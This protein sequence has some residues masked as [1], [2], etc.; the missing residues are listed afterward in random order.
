MFPLRKSVSIATTSP[1]TGAASTSSVEAPEHPTTS[2]VAEPS[3]FPPGDVSVSEEKMPEDL[4]MTSLT[5]SSGAALPKAT[6]DEALTQIMELEKKH[7]D[8]VVVSIRI[9]VFQETL[10]LYCHLLI[11]LTCL[12]ACQAFVERSNQSLALLK[13][14]NQLLAR[15]ESAEAKSAEEQ[16]RYEKQEKEHLAAIAVLQEQVDSLKEKN[17]ELSASLKG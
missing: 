5:T 4:P 1:I 3:T 17:K 8:H 9:N 16:E 14:S 2:V 10:Y 7:H 12:G 6:Q 15:A 13:Q 11:L